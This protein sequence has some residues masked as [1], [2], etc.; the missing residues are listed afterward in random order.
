VA[1]SGLNDALNSLKL[2]AHGKSR[3]HRQ[4]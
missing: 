4:A 3:R 1:S 2:I